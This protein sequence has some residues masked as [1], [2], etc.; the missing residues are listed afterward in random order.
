MAGSADRKVGR[1]AIEYF[2]VLRKQLDG[3]KA[4]LARLVSE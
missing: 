4:D 2:D 1:S 3:I